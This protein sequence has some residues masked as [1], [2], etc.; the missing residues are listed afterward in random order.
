MFN[1]PSL[2]IMAILAIVLS[3]IPSRSAVDSRPCT[4]YFSTFG[5]FCR[6]APEVTIEKE[7]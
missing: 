5:L 4:V 6:L 3:S 2:A 1:P 7:E